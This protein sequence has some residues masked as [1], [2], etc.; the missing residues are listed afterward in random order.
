MHV[1]CS[2]CSHSFNL[3]RDYLSSALVE[4]QSQKHKTHVMEC[5][6]CRKHIKVPVAQMKRFAPAKQES[7]ATN[8]SA[9]A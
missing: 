2:Y 5:P 7:E 6:N 9:D 1:R 3:S 4:A 8:E